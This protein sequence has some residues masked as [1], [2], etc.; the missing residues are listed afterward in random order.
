M[1][2]RG[3]GIAEAAPTEPAAGEGRAPATGSASNGRQTLW[4]MVA[5]QFVT[6]MAN[7]VL[8]PIM[9]LFLPELG[10]T[11]PSEVAIWAGILAGSTSFVAAFTSPI[12][13]RLS[14]QHR[15]RHLHRADGRRGQCLADVRVS[16]AD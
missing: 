6:A 14:D 10:V 7:S 2:E 13:G 8:T 9:P 3:A 12:W 16:R 1:A 15:D 5:I 11:D 4:A